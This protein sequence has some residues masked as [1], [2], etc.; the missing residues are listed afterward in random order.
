MRKADGEIGQL[1]QETLRATKQKDLLLKRLKQ[2]D[3]E[4][5]ALKRESETIRSQVGQLLFAN[6]CSPY[7]GL[8]AWARRMCHG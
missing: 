1:H 2:I 7:V 5:A 6:F 8:L 3:S 4:R